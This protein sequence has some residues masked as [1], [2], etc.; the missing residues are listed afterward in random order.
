MKWN[1]YEL[2][3]YTDADIE[4]IVVII[5]P[6]LGNDKA[7]NN[8][9][10]AWKHQRNPFLKDTVGI[11]A[12]HAGKVVG[13]LGY[14]PTELK[15][16]DAN[17]KALQQ[18]DTVILPEHRGK[19]LFSAMTRA[20]MD[21]YCDEYKFI[22]NFT[23]N[24]ITAAGCLKLGWKPLVT[25]N[26]LRH[27]NWLHLAKY[28]LSGAAR[29]M[30]NPGNFGEVKVSDS[31]HTADISRISAEDCYSEN[32]ICQNKTPDFIEWKLSNP[33]AKYT[34][35][36]HLAE[37]EIDAYLILKVHNIHAHIFDYGQK[38]GSAGMDKIISFILDHARFGSISFCNA[39]MPEDLRSFLRKKHF[40]SFN[41][42]DRIRHRESY[43]IP[44]IVRPTVGNYSDD[45]WF[46]SGVD[47]RDIK[48]WQI[49]EIC[50]D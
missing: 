8:K 9:Y 10:F 1:D 36:Y 42:I 2:S 6:L 38:K 15:I 43:N 37:S 50:F 41:Q 26:Y 21:M 17:F 19:G 31:L 34:Y 48:N 7:S 30:L 23:S 3:K 32:K 4:E 39:G 27:F 47:I 33:G 16:G 18:S 44:I 24:N 12:K 5:S 28:K 14:V 45:D 29:V 49:T 25:I 35:L 46:V 40:H 13:F 20:G 22:V 11:V